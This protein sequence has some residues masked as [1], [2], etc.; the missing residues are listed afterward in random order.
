MSKYGSDKV[1]LAKK[2]RQAGYAYAD[3][4][5]ATGIPMRLVIYYTRFIEPAENGRRPL[6]L[7]ARDLLTL[8]EPDEV[9]P[10]PRCLANIIYG[11][12]SQRGEGSKC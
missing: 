5:E 7:K 1:A 4:A 12:E 3:I 2:M 8:C 10:I 6:M 9:L 11:G